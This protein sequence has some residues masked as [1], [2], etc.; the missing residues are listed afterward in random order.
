MEAGEIVRLAAPWRS[1]L[2]CSVAQG[3]GLV[4]CK[5]IK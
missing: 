5:A 1:T 2:Q 4:H 3:A